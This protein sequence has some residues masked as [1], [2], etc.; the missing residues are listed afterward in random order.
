MS[1]GVLILPG[2]CRPDGWRVTG[3]SN[4]ALLHH[5]GR[6]LHEAG[7]VSALH[8]VQVAVG[9]LAVA[10][11]LLVDGGHDLVELRVDL[12]G[13]PLEVFGVLRHFEAGACHAASVDSLAGGVDGL[14]FDEVV[15]SL[16]GA[17]HVGYFRH[18]FHAVVNQHLRIVAV[19][20][21]LGSAGEGDVYFLLPGLAAGEELRAGEF[22]G[23]RSHDVVAR[24]A[25]FQHVVDLFVVETGGV[26]DVAVRAGDGDY[27]RSELGGL[28]RGAPGYVAEA[29][30]GDC[31]ALDVLVHAAQH[32]L[33]E[34][35]GA[36]AGSL[37]AQARAAEVEALAGEC[38]GV[39]VNQFLVHAVHV[40]YLAATYADVAGGNVAVRAQVLPQAHDEGLAETHDL[41]VALA[42]G[43]E[44]GA[45]LCA[46]HRERCQGVL[47]GLLEAEEFQNRKVDGGVEAD[48]P[49]VRADSVVELHAV[50]DVVL[51]LA[52]VVNPGDAERYDAVRLD[53]ALDDAVLLELGM[54][55][56][57]VG[58]GEEHLAH[59][60]Q[61]FLFARMLGFQ[62][63]HDAIYIHS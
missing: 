33:Y 50:A 25:E 6:H 45:T 37:G 10:H 32:V 24:S 4:Y 14:C 9:L 39:L 38:A 48:T 49:L 46:T 20:L 19:K 62:A 8:V 21:V 55:V 56:V 13:G 36:E 28:H 60:L 27:L 23:V 44:V 43:R 40:A 54:L 30:D 57:D 58:N 52:V 17:A 51:D 16:G 5:C 34:V 59:C 22:L 41:A 12:F 47:E 29:G 1:D 3:T 31:L 7:D 63:V 2:I 15:D 35:E 26:E 42:A 61:V 18:E 11:A 53:H